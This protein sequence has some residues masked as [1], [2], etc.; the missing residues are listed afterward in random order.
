[1]QYRGKIDS[2]ADNALNFERHMRDL[3]PLSTMPPKSLLPGKCTQE[4]TAKYKENAVKAG[5]PAKN[6]RKPFPLPPKETTLDLSTVGLGT[7]LGMPD[8]QD[9]FDM[10]IALTYLA[11][12]GALNV[13]DTAINYRCQKSERIIGAAFRSLFDES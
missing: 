13:V 12:S 2:F 6:F 3:P 11:R 7:Y 1:M 4:A 8:D 10:Y 5:I 9:D